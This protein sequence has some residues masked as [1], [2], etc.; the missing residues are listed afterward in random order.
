MTQRNYYLAI[1]IGASSGRHILGW[2][3]NGTIRLEEIYRFANGLIEK[4][5]HLCWDVDRL[6]SEIINGLKKCRELNRIPASIGIDTWGVDFVLLDKNGKMLGDSVSYRDKRTETMDTQVYNIISEK[7]LYARNGIQKLIFNTIYQLYAIK[8]TQPEILENAKHFLMIPEY[9]NFLLTGQIKNEYT[10]ST[11]TQLVNANTQDWDYELMEMLGIPTEIF[12]K[13]YMPKTVVG[14]LTDEIAKTV[15]FNTEVIL[16]PTHDTAS[17]V[18]AVPTNDYNAIYL[19]SGTWSLM[20]IERMIPDCTELSR[21]HNFTNEGGYHY[22]YRYL[23]NIMGMWMVQSV[24]RELGP[25]ADGKLPSFD[26]LIDEA[27][28]AR[29]DFPLLDVDADRFLAPASM[30]DEVRAACREAGGPVPAEPGEL[31]R[32]IYDSLA[33]D[34]ACAVAELGELTGVARTCIN[35]VGGG[36]QNRYMNQATANACGVP[37]FAGPTEGTALGNLM[38]QMIATGEFASLQEARACVVRSFNIQR[39]DPAC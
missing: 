33:A 7:D 2:V 12:G 29:G 23:K 36:S 24:R 16:P 34:Y 20:G 35:I 1:D 31:V 19:S 37:V 27:F 8:Q 15:G 13:I 28:A 21:Q 18:L 4:N 17:A 6:F 22:R 39:I 26:T 38:A 14:T 9:L 30:V 32:C 10:N 11:T 5:G 3:E 25:R